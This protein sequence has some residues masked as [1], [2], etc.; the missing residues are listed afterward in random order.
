MILVDSSVWIDFFRGTQNSK[1]QILKQLFQST[2]V[3][4][5]DLIL[6]EVLQGFT[7]DA[8]FKEAKKLLADFEVIAISD[9]NVAIAAANNYRTLRKFGFTVRKTIDTLIATRCIE[10]NFRLLHNDSDFDAF[11]KHLGLR[12]LR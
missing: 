7:Q 6:T 2:E 4:V 8:H 5:G 10:D 12:V 3:S 9:P 11:E 1:T